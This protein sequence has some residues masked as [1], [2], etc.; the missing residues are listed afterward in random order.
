MMLSALILPLQASKIPWQNTWITPLW[1]LAVGIAA[2][3]ALAGL[4]LLVLHL[5]GRIPPLGTLAEKRPLADFVAAGLSVAV[6]AG[7]FP[8]LTARAGSDAQG[9]YFIVPSLMLSILAGWGIVF[10]MWRRTMQ[11][12]WITLQEGPLNYMLVTLGGFSLIGLCLTF[13]AIE[14]LDIVK[15]V[16]ASINQQLLGRNQPTQQKEVPAAPEDATGDAAPFVPFDL[17]YT[18]GEFSEVRI[19]TDRAILIAD[20][21]TPEK[22]KM[23]PVRVQPGEVLSW[24]TSSSTPPPIPTDPSNGVFIQNREID[25]AIVTFTFITKPKVPEAIT[26]V[27][28][29]LVVALLILAY[30]ILRQ[31]APRVSAVALATAKNE[32]SQLLFLVLLIIGGAVIVFSVYV[33]FYTMGEDI[34]VLKTTSLTVM[35]ILSIG[36]AVWAAGTSIHDEI[37]GRTALTVLSKPIS[38]RSFWLG[39]MVGILY[40]VLLM[41]VI[42]GLVLM[43]VTAYKPIYDARE[44]TSDRP[45]WQECNMEMLTTAQPM[46]LLLLQAM[47]IAGIAAAL[48]PK[49]PPLANMLICAGIYAVGNLTGTIVQSASDR[50]PVVEFFGNLV[51]VLVPNLDAFHIEA[52]VDAGNPIPVTYLA[53]ATTYAAIFGVLSLMVALLLFEDRDLA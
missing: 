15:S 51:S 5:L 34:K 43:V 42:L 14:P 18:I 20:A 19:E 4:V 8:W 44:N 7:M 23:K 26:I 24:K 39:K 46:A 41:F 50:F 1:V 25:P 2:G 13:F 11:E 49:V 36:Q 17:K 30:V 22:L 45:A 16:P 52:A 28:A 53:I 3:M 29:A 32:M 21:D 10:G 6:F 33:P 12:L 35:M 47:V 31:A 37:E 27:S 40:V 48:A 9:V 38:R